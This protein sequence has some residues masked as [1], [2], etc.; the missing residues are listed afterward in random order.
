MVRRGALRPRLPLKSALCVID[1]LVDAPNEVGVRSSARTQ[2]TFESPA[3]GPAAAAS[4][5]EKDTG[6][7]PIRSRTA[8]V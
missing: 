7:E 6:N 1:R 5:R 2:S 8:M 4:A 3:S